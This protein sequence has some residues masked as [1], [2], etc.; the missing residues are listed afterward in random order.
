MVGSICD[1]D[2]WIGG[3][4]DNDVR[5]CIRADKCVISFVFNSKS[6]L[7]VVVKNRIISLAHSP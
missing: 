1:I 7:G 4:I 2:G 3:K 5:F 6:A